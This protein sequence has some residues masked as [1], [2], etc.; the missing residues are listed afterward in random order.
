MTTTN[1]ANAPWSEEGLFAKAQLYIERMEAHTADD[2]QFGLW[3][4]LALE[5]V[6]RAALA[7]ISPVL[8]ADSNNWRNLTYALGQEPT[9]KKFT[10]NSISSNEV[11]ARLTELIPEVTP[12]IAGFCTQHLKRRNAELHSGE[13]IF[14][15][16]GTS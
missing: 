7:H 3:S 1:V 14:S 6:A 12:E 13:L 5:L 10:P 16:L 2:W 8:L 9:A 4:T 15:E 11:I